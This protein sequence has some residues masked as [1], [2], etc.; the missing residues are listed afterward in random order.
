MTLL[1]GSRRDIAE[2]FGP[3]EMHKQG[4]AWGEP[5]EREPSA[6]ESHG[7][8]FPRDIEFEISL[9]SI[10]HNNVLCTRGISIA[11]IETPALYQLGTHAA[12]KKH[13]RPGGK[14]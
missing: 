13:G 11:G 5:F 4:L 10:V 1:G 2:R 8:G 12:R 7:A 9:Y 6:D 3:V 14:P